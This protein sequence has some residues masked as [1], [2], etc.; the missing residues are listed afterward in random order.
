MTYRINFEGQNLT[1]EER[2]EKHDFENTIRALFTKE[3]YK[4]E[5]YEIGQLG[6]PVIL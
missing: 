2:K 4:L 3:I 1:E 6:V 5:N